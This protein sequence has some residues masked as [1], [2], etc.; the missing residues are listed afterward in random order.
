ERALLDP[1]AVYAGPEAVPADDALTADQKL[2]VLLAWQ[3]NAAE[4]EVALEEG[5]PGN[6]TGMLPRVMAALDQVAGPDAVER[7]GPIK[8]HGLVAKHR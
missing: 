8:Q 7:R 5:M 1:A 2:A 3:Y 6:E 4:E